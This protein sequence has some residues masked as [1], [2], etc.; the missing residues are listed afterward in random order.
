MLFHLQEMCIDQD[1]DLN[2]SLNVIT[3]FCCLISW[4][5]NIWP[6]H[7][8][9]YSHQFLLYSQ[10]QSQIFIWSHA[11]E[12]PM[13]EELEKEK[14]QLTSYEPAPAAVFGGKRP[15]CHIVYK[16]CH[17]CI[18]Y[19][20]TGSITQS[21]LK[22]RAFELYSLL[23]WRHETRD[24]RAAL[25]GQREERRPFLAAGGGRCLSE[26]PDTLSSFLF[27]SSSFWKETW[28]PHR[29]YSVRPRF[30]LNREEQMWF[31]VWD[32]EILYTICC[33]NAFHVFVALKSY[34]A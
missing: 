8:W 18:S 24:V 26:L 30:V 16:R 27:Q 33:K 13:L 14:Q 9:D 31:N 5:V 12:A 2:P 34:G 11:T 32:P 28:R 1:P 19:L 23:L 22:G 20:L 4:K 6:H 29:S 15:C 7:L 3:C 25:E 17:S 10:C 21:R